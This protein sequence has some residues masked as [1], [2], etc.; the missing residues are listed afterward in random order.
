MRRHYNPRKL[1]SWKT[2]KQI[3]SQNPRGSM[4]LTFWF[5]PEKSIRSLWLWNRGQGYICASS[6]AAGLCPL[7]CP[8]NWHT[9]HRRIRWGRISTPQANSCLRSP[10]KLSRQVRDFSQGILWC[11]LFMPYKKSD[12]NNIENSFILH[13]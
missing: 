3:F 12:E 10:A 7:L 8:G 6:Q 9:I 2:S 1:E 13:I 4:L 11:C 5:R